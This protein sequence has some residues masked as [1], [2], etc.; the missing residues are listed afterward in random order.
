MLRAVRVHHIALR[1][2]DLPRLQAFYAGLLGLPV[3]RQDA[4]RGEGARR[5]WLGAGETLVML[6]TAGPG[7]PEVPPGTLEL[8]AFG[9]ARE[10][11]ATYKETLAAAGVPIEAE[12]EFTLYFRDPDGRRVGLSH[13]P[14][15]P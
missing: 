13:Y 11:R 5:V 14:E 9:I 3:T 7:E 12:S 1:T 10:E 8:V 2:R 15:R 6:E 4:V